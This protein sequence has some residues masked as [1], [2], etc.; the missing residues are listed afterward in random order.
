MF[1]N[2]SRSKNLKNKKFE[3]PTHVQNI[4]AIE[5][6]FFL[7]HNAKQ[8]FNCLR[9][10]FI[11]T[12]ILQHFNQEIYIQIEIN[13]AKYSKS[14]LLNQP[15]TDQ[16][17]LDKPDLTKFD[18]GQQYLIAYFTEKMISVETQYETY[19]VELLAI[20]EA[21]K[22]QRFYLKNCKYKVLNLTN[23]NNF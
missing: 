23:Q 4:K 6:L 17:A 1:K 11:K 21:F 5:E 20:F 7:N 12:S 14:K 22:T 10:V 8:D 3:N 19:N 16:I 2:L 18:F 13:T 15:S 9:Q